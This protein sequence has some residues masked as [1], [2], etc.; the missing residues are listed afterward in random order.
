M[1]DE[2]GESTEEYDVT[3]V[4]RGDRQRQRDR[5]EVDGREVGSWFY[6]NELSLIRNEDDVGADEAE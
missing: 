5:D 1:D 3:D 6:R 4:G 2:S